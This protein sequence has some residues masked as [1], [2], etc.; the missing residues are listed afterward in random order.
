[1]FLYDVLDALEKHK[2]KCALVGGY[3]LA[4]HGIV[5]ATVDVDLVLCLREEDFIKAEKALSEISLK[6]RIPVGAKE[7]IAM[8]EEYIKNR[9]L[10]A[11]SFVDYKDP[12]RQV[13]IL[14]NYDFRDLDIVKIKVSGKRIPVA[15]LEQLQEMK[16]LTNRPQDRADVEKIRA[17]LNEKKKS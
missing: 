2:V 10:I 6:S 11:W 5:R 16:E 14:I 17:I 9:N 7:V 4:L 3:A 1:M 15:S 12:M 8:R 13:D